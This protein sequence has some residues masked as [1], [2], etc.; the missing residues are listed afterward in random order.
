MHTAA[1]EEALWAMIRRLPEGTLDRMGPRIVSEMLYDM[2]MVMGGGASGASAGPGAAE[3]AGA[4][5]DDADGAVW[6]RIYER[7]RAV[8]RYRKQL[9]RLLKIPQVPQRSPAWYALRRER[10]TASSAAQAMERG[11]FGT[12]HELLC[13]KVGE[14][15]GQPVPFDSNAPPLRWGVMLEPMAART[16][17]QRKGGVRLHEFGMLPHPALD[18]FG[19]SPDNIS[20]LGIMVEYKCPY[21]RKMDGS[22]PEQYEIQMQG[23]LAVCGLEECDYVEC[24]IEELGGEEGYL[25]AVDADAT[26]DH[27]VILEWSD[28]G[29]TTYD[30][31][32]ED[33]TPGEAWAWGQGRIAEKRAVGGQSLRLVRVHPWRLRKCWIQR[34]RFQ[35][36]RWEREI[37]PH[38]RAFWDDV[39]RYVAAGGVPAP[40]TP[41]VEFGARRKRTAGPAS[42]PPEPVSFVYDSDDAPL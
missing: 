28:G 16:Y 5:A 36:D 6:A 34:V 26:C 42:P 2:W 37:V 17:A 32:P 38:I 20:D 23:Q 13:S 1:I 22:I 31:S 21:R 27:G 25:W 30:Y 11:K 9:A 40:A 19:A 33:L 15:L 24:D 29:D 18:C 39:Q 7:V 8:L 35:P 4:A 41:K 10:L 12:R 14:I 3:A